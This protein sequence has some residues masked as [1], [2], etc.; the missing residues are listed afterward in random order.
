MHVR[1][2][3]QAIVGAI[4]GVGCDLCGFHLIGHVNA[5][6]NEVASNS[7]F[8]LSCA[9]CER[10]V[11]P[12][13]VPKSISKAQSRNYYVILDLNGVLINMILNDLNK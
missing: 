8:L 2:G 10:D 1:L 5:S 12:M 6:D 3:K 13:L 11:A 4:V 9:S 7:F